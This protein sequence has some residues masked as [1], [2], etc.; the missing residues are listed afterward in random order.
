MQE[1][2]TQK[3]SN[4]YTWERPRKMEQLIKIAEILTLNTISAKE[5]KGYWGQWF[6]T[7]EGRKAVDMKVEKQML[8]K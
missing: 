1:K 5:K 4:M 7:S 2:I 6:G 8:G 3:F